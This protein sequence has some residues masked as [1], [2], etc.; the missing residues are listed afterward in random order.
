MIKDQ[1]EIGWCY[2]NKAGKKREQQNVLRKQGVDGG[3]HI[4]V[5]K[6]T[7]SDMFS[8]ENY[9]LQVNSFNN[10][11]ASCKSFVSNPSVKQL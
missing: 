4:G 11:F 8:S 9:L 5:E 6:V 7:G 3:L 1:L 10:A 2:P